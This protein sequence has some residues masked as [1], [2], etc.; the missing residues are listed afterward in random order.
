M[1]RFCWRLK[2]ILGETFL[3]IQRR[4]SKSNILSNCIL[5]DSSDVH[6]LGGSILERGMMINQSKDFEKFKKVL[7]AA[8]NSGSCDENALLTIY[9]YCMKIWKPPVTF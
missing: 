3:D 6:E 8:F 2:Y 9:G 4:L 7:E 5:L 1:N